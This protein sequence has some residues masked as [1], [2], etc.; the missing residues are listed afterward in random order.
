[1]GRRMVLASISREFCFFSV[2]QFLFLIGTH[3]D[4][5]DGDEPHPMPLIR[6]IYGQVMYAAIC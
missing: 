6:Y 5:V 3:R 4:S 2:W 1:M